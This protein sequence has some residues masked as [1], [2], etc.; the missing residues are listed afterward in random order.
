M[1]L[2]DLANF[3]I[4]PQLAEIPG[5]FNIEIVG[6]DQRDIGWSS[7]RKNW[8]PINWITGALP[9]RWNKPT[10]SILWDD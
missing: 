8:L 3:M 10:R 6:G 7:I 9:M 2:W 1:E 5:I 4:R